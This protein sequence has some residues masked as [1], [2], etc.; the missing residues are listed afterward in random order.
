MIKKGDSFISILDKSKKDIVKW[1]TEVDKVSNIRDNA[2][3]NI[4]LMF[5]EPSTRTKFG[6]EFAA[7]NF[8]YNIQDFTGDASSIEKGE[9]ILDTCRVFEGYGTELIVFRHK[10][11]KLV[12]YLDG[13]VDCPFVNAG[14]GAG[15]HPVQTLIDLYMIHK[16]F[17]RIRD[18][19]IAIVGD[20]KNART[21]HSLAYVL[22]QFKSNTL[23]F[24]SPQNYLMPLQYI[25]GNNYKLET[26][27][28][29][30][31]LNTVDVV[32]MTR[33]QIERGS[34]LY[35]LDSLCLSKAQVDSMKKE[36]IILHPM[37]R[38]RELPTILDSNPRS[39]YMKRNKMSMPVY[40]KIINSIIFGN[41]W[42]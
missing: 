32:Y 15:E 6:F 25:K 5:F 39:W 40:T 29:V 16:K 17:G 14:N 18:L 3:R 21:A 24:V 4:T 37:P 11:D 10:D 30:D 22:G 12:K 23:Y 31:I 7:K 27:L 19:K 41:E 1:I 34:S 36:S 28:N 8:G 35:E 13:V 42:R 38:N 33:P 2:P 26:H 9:S 20:L